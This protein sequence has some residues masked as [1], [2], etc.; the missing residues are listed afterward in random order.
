MTIL[1]W[2][3][4]IIAWRERAFR[5]YTGYSLLRS[6]KRAVPMSKGYILKALIA[7][8]YLLFVFL[9]SDMDYSNLEHIIDMIVTYIEGL[10]VAC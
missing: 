1:I 5:A 2:S 8:H 9:I 10:K 6:V 7:L 4:K 3:P